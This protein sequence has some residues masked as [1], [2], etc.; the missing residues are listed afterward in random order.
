MAHAVLICTN[1]LIS[2]IKTQRLLE[3]QAMRLLNTKTI[4][5]ETFPNPETPR[6]P[7]YAIL[8]HTWGQREVSFQEMQRPSPELL[9]TAGYVKVR[10]FCE[11]AISV[12]FEYAWVDTCCVD[13]TNNV[14]LAEAL[15]SM[16]QWYRDAEVC[17]SYLA[18]VPSSDRPLSKTSKFRKSRWFTRG[19]TLQEL[20][21]PLYVVFF[22]DDWTEI[23]TKSSLQEAIS[24]VTGIH[25]QVLLMNYAG[26]ISVAQRMAWASRRETA[27]VEDKA[28]CLMGLFRVNMPMV[29]GEGENAFTRLQLEILKSSDDHSIFAWTAHESDWEQQRGFLARSPKEFAN[30]G[31]VRRSTENL[32]TSAFSMTNKG[33]HIQL[34]LIPCGIPP[35]KSLYLAVLS[36]QGRGGRPLGI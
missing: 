31:D 29:Y 32:Q 7:D 8:S 3:T 34:P 33:L 2:S 5:L 22:G 36:C 13:K 15:N 24:S 27:R 10:R 19:W 14:E 9:K 23:G 11:Q 30:C 26:E 28:Y 17:Y 1:L 18:D 25:S 20:L 16:F 21:A 35:D 6:I 4:I 12:G